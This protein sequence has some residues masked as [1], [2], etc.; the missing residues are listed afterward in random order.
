MHIGSCSKESKSPTNASNQIHVYCIPVKNGKR[1]WKTK[2]SVFIESHSSS[3]REPTSGQ[4]LIWF[5]VSLLILKW[6]SN[7]AYY[8]PFSVSP[9]LDSRNHIDLFMRLI[10]AGE[11][12]RVTVHVCQFCWKLE[13]F[14]KDNLKGARVFGFDKRNRAVYLVCILVLSLLKNKYEAL[15]FN[16]IVTPEMSNVA[17]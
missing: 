6:L 10:K 13:D 14:Q 8:W 17:S 5:R 11:G 3:P 1:Q 4:A 15:C 16:G 12:D 9:N 7:T 2:W